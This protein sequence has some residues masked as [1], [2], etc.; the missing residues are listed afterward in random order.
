M[1][2]VGGGERKRSRIVARLTDRG[3]WVPYWFSWEPC[4]DMTIQVTEDVTPAFDADLFE[5]TQWVYCWVRRTDGGWFSKGK[6]VSYKLR[7]WFTQCLNTDYIIVV[8]SVAT[9]ELTMIQ[10]IPH[11]YIFKEI[12][13]FNMG[14][15]LSR[16]M[17]SDLCINSLSLSLIV[18]PFLKFQD[19]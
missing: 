5:E 14:N 17:M 10:I 8:L 12:S 18:E 1:G 9:T 13:T 15:H 16:H 11:T 19:T 6:A 7:R 3:L 4:W 2:I